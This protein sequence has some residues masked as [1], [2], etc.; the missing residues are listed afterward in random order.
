MIGII[1]YMSQERGIEEFKKIIS[2]YEK[3]GIPPLPLSLHLSRNNNYVKFE[4]GDIWK[5]VRCGDGA[6][7]HRWNVAYIEY[8]IPEED[9]EIFIYPYGLNYIWC[10]TKEYY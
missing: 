2:N 9:R 6:R 8:M 10:A 4:N 3:Q 5:T 7:G 1:Y